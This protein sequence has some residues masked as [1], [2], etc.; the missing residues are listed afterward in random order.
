VVD[1]G[2]QLPHESRVPAERLLRGLGESLQLRDG[3][4]GNDEENLALARLDGGNDATAES[5]EEGRIARGRAIR[6]DGHGVEG[7]FDGARD[8]APDEKS[9]RRPLLVLED[10]L[11][12]DDARPSPFRIR[13]RDVARFALVHLRA[14]D[15]DDELTGRDRVLVGPGECQRAGPARARAVALR[16]DFR[17]GVRRLVHPPPRPLD[18]SPGAVAPH[19]LEQGDPG[20]KPEVHDARLVDGRD[21]AR[22]AA[23][24][25]ELRRGRRGAEI[26]DDGQP[27]IR[28][29]RHERQDPHSLRCGAHPCPEHEKNEGKLALAGD[30]RL[31]ILRL[32]PRRDRR[33]TDSGS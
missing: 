22:G 27:A 29:A 9:P 2:E 26:D 25:K 19:E 5:L 7:R 14:V 18:D 3:R 11:D 13:H 4:R 20:R 6:K 8:A 21:V 1:A 31:C 28:H 30:H 23:V 17:A 33:G 15:R 12:C 10:E 24:L 32:P 16:E